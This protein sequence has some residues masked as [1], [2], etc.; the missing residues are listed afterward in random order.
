MR[1]LCV[2]AKVRK[3]TISSQN[4]KLY[5]QSPDKLLSQSI[6]LDETEVHPYT[7]EHKKTV[8]IV[9]SNLYINQHQITVYGM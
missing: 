2:Q 9:N 1:Y 8:K 7:P 6:T 5:Q 4:F 3:K